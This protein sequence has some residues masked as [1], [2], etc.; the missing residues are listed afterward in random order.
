[1]V[2][3]GEGGQKCLKICPHGLWMPLVSDGRIALGSIS[4]R[5]RLLPQNC[6]ISYS[7]EA[8]L[9]VNSFQDDRVVR[10]IIG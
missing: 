10:T 7:E 2:H 4:P 1:M 3:E 6:R 5:Y 8:Q 9:T